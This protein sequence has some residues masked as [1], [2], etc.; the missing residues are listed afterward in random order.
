MFLKSYESGIRLSGIS[1]AELYLVN[2][3]YA[4]SKASWNSLPDF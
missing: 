2:H 4:L 1:A 3:D